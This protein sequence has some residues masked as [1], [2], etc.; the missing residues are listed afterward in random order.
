MKREDLKKIEGL[1]DDQINAVLSLHQKDVTGWNQRLDDQ[2]SE[3]QKRDQ[4]ITE[5]TEK[6]QKYNGVDVEQLQKDINE[7]E[8]KY[9]DGLAAKDK[10]YAKQRFFDSIPFASN[11]A[12]KAAM[13]DFDAKELEF[14]DGKFIGA[15]DFIETLKK[16][17]PTA[18]KAE[19]T[20]SRAKSTG[21]PHGGSPDP[22]D[23]G[24]TAHFKELNPNLK[25]D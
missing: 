9:N 23:D 3:I 15:N 25:I 1:N 14:K 21:L 10:E 17:D 22:K 20:G 4:T 7:W 13:A 5:L 6:V 2:K 11:L 19:D 12:R 24:V 18:F 8:Q 16:E